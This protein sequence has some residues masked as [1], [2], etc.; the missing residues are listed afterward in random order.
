MDVSEG[1]SVGRLVG[2]ETEK[3]GE[4]PIFDVLVLDETGDDLG[5]DHSLVGLTEI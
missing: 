4:E 3:E 2:E 5:Q 1:I